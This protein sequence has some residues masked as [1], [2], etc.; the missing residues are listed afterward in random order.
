[1]GLRKRVK[2]IAP[3]AIL[4]LYRKIKSANHH[5]FKRLKNK[6][7]AKKYKALILERFPDLKHAAENSVVLDLGANIGSFTHACVELGMSVKSVEPHPIAFRYLRNRTKRFSKVELYEMAVSDHSG[8]IKLFTHPQ[9][10]NDPITTSVSASLVVDKFEDHSGH[11]EVPSVTL[12]HF[13]VT[14]VVYEI[15]KIDIEGAEMYLVDQ[16]IGN[17]KSIKRLL[18]ET[19]ERFMMASA[20]SEKYQLQLQKLTEYI[21]RNK[22]DKV[23]LLDWI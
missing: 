4:D 9:Q 20:S 17:S 12:D 3:S 22:L 11:Y 6:R 19:H 10:K 13:F 7:S 8:S 23:W 5:V 14:D 18:V 2:R 15:V 21:A 16:L 1:M